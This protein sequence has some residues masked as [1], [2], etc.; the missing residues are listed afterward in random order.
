[1]TFPSIKPRSSPRDIVKILESLTD[2]Q[3]QNVV[4][5]GF[6]SLL[7]ENFKINIT[8]TKLGYWVIDQ[9]DNET[10]TTKMGDGRAIVITPKMIQE[11]I[12]IMQM[13]IFFYLAI[14]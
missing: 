14:M 12:C 4:E 2:I 6:E 3:K 10:C 9:F 8:P 5:M 13:Y 7:D 1:M 11:L